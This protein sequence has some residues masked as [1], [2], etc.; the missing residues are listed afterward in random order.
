MSEKWLYTWCSGARRY[1]SLTGL[2][3]A[4]ALLPACD[5]GTDPEGEVEPPNASVGANQ[6]VPLGEIVTLNGGGSSDPQFLYLSYDWS[7]L[8]RPVGSN[9]VLEHAT[10]PIATFV[11]DVDGLYQVTLTVSNGQLTDT[12]T[13]R[14][15]TA[16]DIP[17]V[18]NQDI[19][20]DTYLRNLYNNPHAVD[21]VVSLPIEVLADLTI[22]DGVH[23]ETRGGITITVG[24]GGSISA[25]GTAEE[26]I[27]VRGMK[28]RRGYWRGIEVLAGSGENL[29]THIELANG[30]GPVPNE[31]NPDVESFEGILVVRNGGAITVT[32]ALIRDSHTWGVFIEQG[33]AFTGTD[34]TYRN[35]TLGNVNP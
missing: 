20:I 2:L 31:N 22:E 32:D 33:G 24:E 15:A 29:L 19:E 16:P 5:S 25:L 34:V 12:D 28:E 17:E 10:E 14:V 8:S 9:A 13:V 21:Y 1:L 7:F 35:N 3:L 23:I 30:G 4:L 11:P 18:I 26:P 27:M 6:N